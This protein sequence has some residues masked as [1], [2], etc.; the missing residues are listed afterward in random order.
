[1]QDDG[2]IKKTLPRIQWLSRCVSS[3]HSKQFV[4]AG[5][6]PTFHWADNFLFDLGYD[7]AG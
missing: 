3:I 1:M 7:N 2:V 4:I 5:L 6:P